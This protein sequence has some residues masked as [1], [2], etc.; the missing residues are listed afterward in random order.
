MNGLPSNRVLELV[1][2]D[3]NLSQLEAV[4]KAL[5]SDT[6]LQIL[7]F[8]G[9]HTCSLLEIAEALGLPQST[10]TLHIKILENAGLIKTD[11][12][13]AKRGVQK[14]CAR[15]Y[16]RIVVQLP[17]DVQEQEVVQ[18][19][20]MPLGAYVEANVMPTCGLLSE[21]GIIG[22]LDDPASF[23]EPDRMR[24]QLLWFRSGFV[25]YRF[26]RRQPLSGHLAGLELSFEVCSEAPLHHESWPSDIT[27]WINGMEIGTWTSPADFG[28]ERGFLT[29]AWWDTNNTQYGLLKI[30]KINANGTYVDG[31]RVSPVT[32][33]D[34]KLEQSPAI[35]VRIG[36]KEDARHPGGVNLFGSRFG[37]YPQDIILKLIYS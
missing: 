19:V 4:T 33:H 27:V 28:G 31:I 15:V 20:S 14:V 23:F 8:L 26:P 7:R 9:T 3:D 16:D 2:S 18:Q 21:E 11:L 30:W 32:L 35:A 29:P 12:E 17:A 5:G 1:G 25:E 22:H 10:A 6:R 36:V 13:P 34:L 37:N 24:A